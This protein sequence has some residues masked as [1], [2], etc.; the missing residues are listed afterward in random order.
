MKV[1]GNIIV[2]F[3]YDSKKNNLVEFVKKYKIVLFCYELV[4]IE[5][6]I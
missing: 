4:G 2:L 5:N 1:M 6:I 3:V